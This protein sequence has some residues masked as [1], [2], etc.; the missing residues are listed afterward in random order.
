MRRSLRVWGLPG[1]LAFQLI[2]GSLQFLDWL[3]VVYF[4]PQR[5]WRAFSLGFSL[6]WPMVGLMVVWAAFVFRCGG[7]RSL[8][9][10]FPLVLAFFDAELAVSL[11]S[12]CMVAVGL[13]RLVDGDRFLDAFM[14]ILIIFNGVSV[15][16]YGVLLPLGASIPFIEV[17]RLQVGVHYV[18]GYLAPLMVFSFL[19]FWLLRPLTEQIVR[20]PRHRV[21]ERGFTVFGLLLLAFSVYLSFYAAQYPYLPAV[22][23]N[24]VNFGADIDR[25]V[26]VIEM[27]AGSENPLLQIVTVGR[28]FFYVFFFAFQ[29]LTGLDTVHAVRLLPALLNPMYVLA[30]FYFA[31]EC[32]RNFEV[33]AWS[34]FFASTGFVVTLGMSIFLVSNNLALVLALFSLGLLFRA[35]RLRGRLCLVAASLFGG[36]LVFTHPWT[37]AQYLAGVLVLVLYLWLRGSGGDGH[38]LG[39]VIG[40]LAVVGVSELSASLLSVNDSGASVASSA[41]QGLLASNLVWSSTLYGFFTINAGL[42]SNIVL[43]VLAAVGLFLLGRKDSW[44]VYTFFLVFLSSIVFLFGDGVVKTRLIFNVPFGFFAAVGLDS[45]RERSGPVLPFFVVAY[46]LFYLFVSLCYPF[47]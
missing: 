10:A 25:Y 39:C 28:G 4:S 23:P 35:I 6:L 14:M 36:L 18:L 34:S 38:A 13:L 47:L 26:E 43:M 37:M 5:M 30:S 11:A 27:I 29:G 44:E 1:T 31:W 16:H 17:T 7:R 9:A 19:F 22:N 33:A 40:Y 2:L 42:L 46:S 20:L 12:L 15:V 3:G 24:D 8:W 45:L 32:F 21:E 41:V